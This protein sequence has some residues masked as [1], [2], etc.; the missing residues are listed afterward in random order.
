MQEVRARYMLPC[1]AE[2]LVTSIMV[3][4]DSIINIYCVP[5]IVNDEAYRFRQDGDL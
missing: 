3:I 4:I 2:M 1:E 5:P